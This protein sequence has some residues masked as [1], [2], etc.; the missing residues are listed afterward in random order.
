M[1]TTARL[2]RSTL[3]RAVRV[4]RL[5][6]H[7]ERLQIVELLERTG[8]APVHQIMREL[9]LAQAVVSQH[10]GRMRSIGLLV[11]ERHG[12]EVW[13][14]VSDSHCIGVLNCLRREANESVQY[15]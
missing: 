11:A 8:G 14:K 3:E 9:G 5:L 7:S 12:K 13:Y 10:L 4:L 15:G 6:A 2:N 1:T